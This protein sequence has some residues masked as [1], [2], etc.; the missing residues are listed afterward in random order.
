MVRGLFKVLDVLK[1]SSI[2]I[3]PY[4]MIVIPKLGSLTLWQLAQ[5]RIELRWEEEVLV[6]G[7]MSPESSLLEMVRDLIS[8]GEDG[9]PILTQEELDWVEL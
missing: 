6:S 2:L 8:K 9:G 4:S 1:C 3:G 5:V 7:G